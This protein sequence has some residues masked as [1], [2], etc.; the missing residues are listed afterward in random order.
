MLILAC[1]DYAGHATRIAELLGVPCRL[2]DIH[3]FPDGESR[4]KVPLP[5]PAHVVFVRTLHQPNAKLVELLLAAATARRHGARRLTLVAPYLCY[6]RQDIEFTPG[7]A[8][9]QGI[10]GDFLG[11]LF[12][13]VLTVDPHL[14][15]IDRLEEAI[16]RG[17]PVTLSAAVPLARL[18]TAR[19]PEALLIG[20][21]GESEQWVA[22]IAAAGGLECAISHKVRHGDRDVCV[23]LP[24]ARLDGRT[25]VLIDDI[26][27]TGRTLA[28]AAMQLKARGAR[29]VH[30]AV[31]HALIDAG[32]LAALHA[33]GVDT[34]L[35]S[36]SVP[37]PSNAIELEPLLAEAVRALA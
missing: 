36:N 3:R 1:P 24:Q 18:I 10:V 27:S 23:S 2:L 22:N 35:S 20:P 15:R 34:F 21:D 25:V 5:L 7:E 13:D 9:S 8:V 11:G 4:V 19:W 26:A 16:P 37:H 6:M 17:N 30:A 31:T 12:D 28:E 14:H 29:A 32:S 33:A